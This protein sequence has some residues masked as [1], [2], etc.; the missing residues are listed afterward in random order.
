MP[1]PKSTPKSTPKRASERLNNSPGKKK[2]KTGSRTV[3]Q[4][5]KEGKRKAGASV[6]NS[7]RATKVPRSTPNNDGME[8]Y[9]Q[10]VDETMSK[11]AHSYSE[12][13]KF[14]GGDPVQ[15]INTVF[16]RTTTRFGQIALAWQ[17]ILGGKIGTAEEMHNLA[18]WI[19]HLIQSK[20]VAT[21]S[22]LR[23]LKCCVHTVARQSQCSVCL[24]VPF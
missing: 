2:G 23:K 9:V 1:T 13:Q 6:V 8:Q 7:K 10:A 12:F 18:F 14:M 24:L 21:S 17:K 11:L 15:R 5:G 19:F 20:L 22:D 3:D 16:K 4:Q